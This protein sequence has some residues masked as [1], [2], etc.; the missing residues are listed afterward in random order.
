MSI[1]KLP[2]PTLSAQLLHRRD[3]HCGSV[4]RLPDIHLLKALNY[5]GTPKDHSGRSAEWPLR[6]TAGLMKPGGQSYATLLDL[7]SLDSHCPPCGHW[8]HHY[9]CCCRLHQETATDRR[10]DPCDPEIPS[11]PCTATLAPYCRM[12][13]SWPRSRS[14]AGP[15]SEEAGWL[16]CSR[17]KDS[18]S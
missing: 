11:L 5:P 7:G 15:G 17:E 1:V 4:Y 12:D 3:V 18:W 13:I 6:R 16:S 9:R 10:C 8:H 14:L 2:I